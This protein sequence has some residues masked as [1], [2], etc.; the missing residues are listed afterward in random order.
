MQ[1]KPKQNHALQCLSQETQNIFLKVISR[2][3][4]II[5]NGEAKG[6]RCVR[7]EQTREIKGRENFRLRKNLQN[8]LKG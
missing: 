6:K 3:D 2:N 4:L 5:L 7:T 8:I 1:A